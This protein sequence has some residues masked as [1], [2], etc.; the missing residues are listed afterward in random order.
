MSA[1]VAIGIVAFR[2][3]QDIIACLEALGR[4]TYE[5]FE[6]VIC[7]NGGAAAFAALRSAVAST[8]PGGQ[9]VR[10]IDAGGNVGYAGGV[11][12]CLADA[13]DADMWWVLNPDTQP[14]PGALAALVARLERGDCEMVGGVLCKLNGRIQSVGGRWRPWLARAESIGY[15]WLADRPLDVPAIERATSYV[16]G[17][18]MLVGRRFLEHV[19]PMREEYFLYAEEVE[20]CLRGK[21]MGMRF[22]LAPDAR[23]LHDH[24]TTTGS[25]EGLRQRPR[26]PIYLDERNRMLVTRDCY[27]A[28]LPVAAAAAFCQI[29]LRF[30][31]RGALRQTG[32]ALSGWLAGIA[33]RR[34]VPGWLST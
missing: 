31:R 23:V 13:A 15:G 33:N 9:Q 8:L 26:L 1:R 16:T 28:R 19:G 21:A 32:Y 27:P 14:E 20:W 4:C 25:A 6:V 30:T 22:G 11:N 7:E 12:R 29:F 10:V 17:A 5:N 34:G 24:G 2:N 3:M 18:S